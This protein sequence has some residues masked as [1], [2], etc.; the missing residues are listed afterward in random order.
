LP[1]RDPLVLESV[2]AFMR[3]IDRHEWSRY[4]HCGKG[5]F[6]STAPIAPAPARLLRL[7]GPP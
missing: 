5:Q 3:R 2:D 4:P 7:R 1:A 6:V